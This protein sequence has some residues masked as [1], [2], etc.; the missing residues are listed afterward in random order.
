[1][2]HFLLLLALLVSA[3]AFAADEDLGVGNAGISSPLLP[4]IGQN[5]AQTAVQQNG[6]SA[7]ARTATPTAGNLGQSVTNS[8]VTPTAPQLADYEKNTLSDVF[9]AQLFT[10]AFA[11]PGASQ[12]NPSYTIS[13]GDSIQ[14]K[15]WG[16]YS[17]E[18]I[19]VVDPKGNIFIP[20]VGPV[21]VLGVKNQDLQSALQAA[22]GQI[23][24][25]NVQSYASLAA[26]QPVRIYVGGFVH[27]PGLY[28][29]TSLDSLLHYLDQAGGV[30]PER[31]S[32]LNIQVKRDGVIRSE[33]N[34]YDFLL[35]GV[36][37][38]V[39]FSD[40]DVIF[41]GQRQNS[42]LVTGM[43]Q[44]PKR[45]EFQDGSIDVKELIQFAKP[46]AVVTHLRIK[47][48]TGTVMNTE[49]FPISQTKALNI[50][51]GDEIEFTS[52]K[53]PGTIA[54]R[55]Q[56]E[57]LSQQEYILP[58]GTRLGELIKAI[59]FT[60]R[61]DKTSLQLFRQSVKTRQKAN[62]DLT[63]KNLEASLLT[64]RSG[65]AEEAGL[66]SQEAAL[67]LQWVDRAKEIEPNGQVLIA[68]AETRDE[69]LLESGDI[70][71]VPVNDNL[72]LVS[73][74]VLFPNTIVFDRKYSVNDYIQLAGG[75]TQNA[76][77]S[78]IIVAHRDG[79]YDDGSKI[80]SI[81]AGD[82]VMILPKV[83]VKSRQLFKDI[84]QMIF[85]LAV[86]ARVVLGGR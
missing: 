62:L 78:R 75:Y 19:L 5:N 43:V 4:G 56:G 77:N 36:M 54:V 16:G 79:S 47:R 76:D 51:S 39:Q 23:F 70:I 60:E 1:M 80:K 14:V 45:F 86:G 8:L 32:F 73:G 71:N 40:G 21:K 72:V 38:L 35:K 42:V 61:S 17:F 41:V 34:L 29:G 7:N 22:I 46:T 28:H 9:G 30:D 11:K 25:S 48:N 6:Q 50:L 84:T 10:G 44:N 74:E 85:Q 53:R 27:R 13:V 31:G 66:R 63:L 18:N 83:D 81:A 82:Q 12:F 67:V 24:T 52:D 68:K 59:Q 33:V 55:V 37:P 2:K 69:L 49:Y 64:A 57:H 58:Y 3:N 20:E 15:L 26:A 65:T